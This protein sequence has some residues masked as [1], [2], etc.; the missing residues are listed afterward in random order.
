MAMTPTLAQIGGKPVFQHPR[1]TEI[2]PSHNAQD[3][4]RRGAPSAACCMR[5]LRTDLVID[6]L[7]ILRP[8]PLD[9][10]V[11]RAV[12]GCPLG[13]SAIMAA[14]IRPK[15]VNSDTEHR[16]VRRWPSSHAAVLRS[17]ERA[18]RFQPRSRL[19][20]LIVTL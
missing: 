10:T 8:V 4:R 5:A 17:R 11:H 7:V 16:S 3:E 2:P 20:R 9:F 18:P 12:L 6:R 13:P 15:G 19:R 14:E 1:P